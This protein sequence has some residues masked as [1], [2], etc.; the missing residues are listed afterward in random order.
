VKIIF[1][2]HGQTVFNKESRYQGHTDAEL[3]DLGR[4][5]AERVADFLANKKL[6][7]VYSS[8]LSRAADT[9]WSIASR[10][11]FSVVIDPA[12]REC[13]FGDWEG[14]TVTEIREK[15]PQ[16]YADY[17]RDSITY[18]APG[19]ERLENLQSRTIDAVE[20]I[21]RRHPNEVIAVIT[22]GGP[23]RAFVCYALE[24]G[25][26]SFRKIGLDNAGVTTLSREPNGCWLLE[27]LNDAC[28]MENLPSDSFAHDETSAI[29][30][31]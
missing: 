10:H 14:L 26:E 11:G 15:Y 16:L 29:E 25:L 13:G 17:R 21:A 20:G 5:Q 7:A 1:V 28:F 2:R 12:L 27:A 19:G 30:K 4:A 23:I 9:A 22:H 6:D 24:A 8:D 31:R 18:R 3:S